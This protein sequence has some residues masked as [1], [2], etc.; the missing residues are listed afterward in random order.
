MP[1]RLFIL[2][3]CVAVLIRQQYKTEYPQMMTICDLFAH[4]S[5]VP[6][7]MCAFVCNV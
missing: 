7:G 4:L 5:G 3:L 6:R 2:L 1:R